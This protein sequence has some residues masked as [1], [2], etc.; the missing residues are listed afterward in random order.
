MKQGNAKNTYPQ[1]Q[2]TCPRIILPRLFP[3]CP[4]RCPSMHLHYWDKSDLS[5]NIINKY[6]QTS[7]PCETHMRCVDACI[8]KLDAN[9]YSNS[10]G[11]NTIWLILKKTSIFVIHF[12]KSV[13]TYIWFVPFFIYLLHRNLLISVKTKNALKTNKGLFWFTPWY[14]AKL[15]K[16]VL[17]LLALIRLSIDQIHKHTSLATG[18]WFNTEQ[19]RG[20][21]F[22]SK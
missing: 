15:Y 16:T 20:Y 13:H 19:I 7:K 4:W 9:L 8:F 3:I 6:K 17:W 18:S 1:P 10:K 5:P 11:F 14:L 22:N 12:G 21:I 2:N